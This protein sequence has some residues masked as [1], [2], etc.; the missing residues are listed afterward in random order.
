MEQKE[1]VGAVAQ[2]ASEGADSL[3]SAA[4]EEVSAINREEPELAIPNI[5]LS[6]ESEEYDEA[7]NDD[8]L[9]IPTPVLASVWFSE[10]QEPPSAEQLEPFEDAL[11]DAVVQDEPVFEFEEKVYSID[12]AAKLEVDTEQRQAKGFGGMIRKFIEM[13]GLKKASKGSGRILSN[14]TEPVTK[15]NPAVHLGNVISKFKK[16]KDFDIKKG[17]RGLFG[18]LSR[19][20]DNGK[21]T[22]RTKAGKFKNFESS[23]KNLSRPMGGLTQPESVGLG[24]DREAFHYGGGVPH[25]QKGGQPQQQKR[26]FRGSLFRRVQQEQQQGSGRLGRPIPQLQS[27]RR[28]AESAARK[29]NTMGRLDRPMPQLD[30]NVMGRLDRPMPKPYNPQRPSAEAAARKRNAMDQEQRGRM[31]SFAKNRMGTGRMMRSEGGEMAVPP[32]LEDTYPNIPPEEMEAAKASQ[33]PDD[34]ME[35]EYEEFI[36]DEALNEQEQDY[37]LEALEQDEN[38]STIFD[39]LMDVA[40][41]FSGA[42]AVKGNGTGVSDSIPARLSDGEFVFTKK[43]VDEIGPEALQ[44]IM[45]EAERAFD[46]SNGKLQKQ[47]GG[48][49]DEKDPT[50][51]NKK[52][53]ESSEVSEELKKAMLDANQMPRNQ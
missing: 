8:V 51:Y 23:F 4:R 15:G 26:P 13:K 36:L 14:L 21:L 27:Q 17:Q 32:E 6:N 48:L 11:I 3:L 50:S 42:G 24:V 22:M 38:L 1:K 31:D 25:G 43:A 16:F 40:T 47:V 28:G 49:V 12:K 37:L 30:N 2:K 41:E 35:S 20:M 29:R 52:F 46:E 18:K 19:K 9:D 39:R 5:P 44:K 45:D 7:D 33:L 53:L 10:N 34:Q